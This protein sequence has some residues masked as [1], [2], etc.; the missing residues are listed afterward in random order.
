MKPKK[1]LLVIPPYPYLKDP[2]NQRPLG[3]LYVSSWLKQNMHH[4]VDVVGVVDMSALT[5]ADAINRLSGDINA[6]DAFG[7]T[8]TTMDYA[9]VVKIATALKENGAKHI[10]AGGVHP[11]V[12][13]GETMLRRDSVCFDRMFV[14]DIEGNNIDINNL[15]LPDRSAIPSLT[16]SDKSIFCKS[17]HANVAASSI[18]TSRGCNYNCAFCVSGNRYH[19]AKYRN[20]ASVLDELEQLATLGPVNELRIQDDNLFSSPHFMEIIMALKRYNILWRAS[21]RTNSIDEHSAVWAYNCGCREI[22]LGIECAD[23]DVLDLINKRTK[24]LH[25]KAAI[26]VAKDAG[27]AVR[28]F[29][30]VN[31][32]GE[33]AAT[34]RRNKEFIEETRPDYVTLCIF[35]PFPGTPIYR[36]PA[37][38]GIELTGMKFEDYNINIRPDKD[39]KRYIKYNGV[40]E[41]DQLERR[42]S[43]IN[44]LKQKNLA[45][46]G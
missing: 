5:V 38:Y 13:Y 4:L 35:N 18:I 23:Q 36:N 41:A 1:L 26:Q 17:Y 6:V 20:A 45:N 2:N 12:A 42:F 46:W 22:G 21:A 43:M 25:A 15:P 33:S 24:I 34:I 9:N 29:M 19:G 14:G 31:L 16:I 11:T 28:L 40:I 32:P 30:M 39:E 10:I 8:M 44:Y 3:V 7:F 37:K 27:I